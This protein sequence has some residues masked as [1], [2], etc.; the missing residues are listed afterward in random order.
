MQIQNEQNQLSNPVNTKKTIS[1]GGSEG[2]IEK[3]PDE[4]NPFLFDSNSA[5]LANILKKAFDGNELAIRYFQSQVENRQANSEIVKEFLANVKIEIDDI[6]SNVFYTPS[7]TFAKIFPKN[8]PENDKK[9]I[10]EPKKI[11]PL[12]ETVGYLVARYI[13]Q[14]FNGNVNQFLKNIDNSESSEAL[15]KRITRTL[16]RG[17]KKY[18]NVYEIDI[19]LYD[20][21]Y[22]E[23]DD[24]REKGSSPLVVY[25]MR[26]AIYAYEGDRARYLSY[27]RNLGL[28]ERKRLR[29]EGKILRLKPINLTYP[30]YFRDNL[31]PNV[32]KD[33]LEQE[34][35]KPI[36]GRKEFKKMTP[37]EKKTFLEQIK[38][39]LFFFDT[40]YKGTVP[41]QIMKIMNFDEEEIEKR[42][43]LLSAP[44]EH[45]RVRG[46]NENARDEIIESIEHNAKLENTAT[47]LYF[48]DKIDKI[49]HVAEPTTPEEQFEFMM[50]KQAIVRHYW[51]KEK[52]TDDHN[53]TTISPTKSDHSTANPTQMQPDGDINW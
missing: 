37:I 40:G 12:E 17:I 24:L 20:K 18:L 47:G 53:S 45:R 16:E 25:L 2:L 26:D 29:V 51:L 50:I 32:K 41:E 21:L 11:K 13:I 35:I 19:P 23:F 48:D 10:T 4:R 43:R 14:S 28:E 31:S 46:I 44:V 9:E 7:K 34:F 15:L 49:K 22:Q 39:Q 42:I 33:F 38:Q 1:L 6:I 27:L 5:Y 36:V 3:N 8:F 30:R 52:S